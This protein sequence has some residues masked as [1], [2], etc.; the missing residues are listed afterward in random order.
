MGGQVVSTST[1]PHVRVTRV[2]SLFLFIQVTCTVTSQL[3]SQDANDQVVQLGQVKREREMKAHGGR[4]WSC[5]LQ[6]GQS[7]SHMSAFN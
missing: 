1:G 3:S 6:K 2:V 5:L 4:R 7:V